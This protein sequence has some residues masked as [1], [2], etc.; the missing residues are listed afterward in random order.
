MRLELPNGM[1]ALLDDSDAA[2]LAGRH[3]HADRRPHTTYV[4]GRLK[5]ETKG[6]VYLHTL[7]MGGLA[8]HRDGNGLDCR[9]EN[10]RIATQAQNGLN[11]AP[12]AGRRFKGVCRSRGKFY[13]EIYIGGARYASHGHLTEESAALAYDQ[14]AIK[15]HG[16]WARTNFPRETILRMLDRV[17][18]R[19]SEMFAGAAA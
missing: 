2:V 16:D 4:R 3:W 8:D 7:I 11:R 19:Q 5:G 10:L 15:H 6:G 13:A 18:A 17:D 14:L 9:R 1:T 12:K